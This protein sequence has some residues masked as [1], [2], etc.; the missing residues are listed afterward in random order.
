MFIQTKIVVLILVILFLG[1]SALDNESENCDRVRFS[2]DDQEDLINKE[3]F[4]EQSFEKNGKPVY[5]SVSGPKNQWRYTR[6]WWNDENKT[7]LSQTM[8]HS[9][10]KIT[11]AKSK[12]LHQWARDW[13]ADKIVTN[14]RCL[15]YDSNCFSNRNDVE[16]YTESNGNRQNFSS[17]NPCKF[18]FK[19]HGTIYNSCIRNRKNAF[20]CATSV[21]A[22]LDWQTRGFCN[23]L[24]PL[25]GMYFCFISQRF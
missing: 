1:C 4:T 11:K 7:W 19:F 6:I 8:T 24:C 14:P 18:P 16:I 22:N 2:S 25:E 21:D 5:Y 9:S 17:K 15:T 10:N 3:N 23:D 12:V 20:W 13:K